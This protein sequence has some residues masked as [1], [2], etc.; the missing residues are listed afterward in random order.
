MNDY[1][2]TLNEI[3]TLPQADVLSFLTEVCK[4][5]AQLENFNWT[6]FYL[7]DDETKTLKLGPFVGAETDHKVIPYGKGICGQVAVSGE[8]FVVRDVSEE[9]NYLA[10]SLDTKSEI[11][12]PVYL[13]EKLIGQIDIDGH[14]VGAFGSSEKIFLEEVA[15]FCAP[16]LQLFRESE[17]K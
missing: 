11:V 10:C 5:I 7:M 12:V 6:G 16:T 8:T 14:K 4:R 17:L 3:K 2:R 9:D 13:H 15:A 1:A